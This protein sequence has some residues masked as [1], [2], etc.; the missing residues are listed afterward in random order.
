[1][2]HKTD[3]KGFTLIELLVVIAIIAILAAMLLPALQNAREKARAISCMN[4]QRQLGLAIITYATDSDGHFPKPPC[5]AAS[6]TEQ[7][8]RYAWT[9]VQSYIADLQYGTLYGYIQNEKTWMCPSDKGELMVSGRPARP[10]TRNFSYSLNEQMS[11]DACGPRNTRRLTMIKKPSDR[12]IIFEEVAPN[13]GRC[14]WTSADDHQTERHSGKANFVFADGHA[15]SGT[16]DEVWANPDL[17]SLVYF[18]E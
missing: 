15:G 12:I 3:S 11:Y 13:D 9:M 2:R 17:C 18:G 8:S 16:E 4:N 6:P 1:M 10:G 7:Y 14:V 5:Q